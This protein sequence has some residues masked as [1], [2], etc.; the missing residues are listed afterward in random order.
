ML[1]SVVRVITTK[2]MSVVLMFMKPFD[3]GVCQFLREFLCFTFSNNSLPYLPRK[4][5]QQ[6][7]AR[8]TKLKSALTE[9]DITDKFPNRHRLANTSC[10]EFIPN[11]EREYFSELCLTLTIN[12]K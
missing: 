5:Y 10:R 4:V 11:L 6:V 2:E 8:D 7:L 1:Q 9:R 12:T 3:A